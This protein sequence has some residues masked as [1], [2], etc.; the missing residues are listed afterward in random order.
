MLNIICENLKTQLETLPFSDKVAGLTKI[1]VKHVESTLDDGSVY[2]ISESRFPVAYNVSGV[3]CQNTSQ[4]K[5]ISPDSSKKSVMYFEQIASETIETDTTKALTHRTQLRLVVWLNLK[6]LGLDINEE[7]CQLNAIKNQ[8][9]DLVSGANKFTCQNEIRANVSPFRIV[10][11]PTIFTKYSYDKTL[12][13]NMLL[14]PYAYF[15]IDFNVSWVRG[16]NCYA[17]TLQTPIVC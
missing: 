10:E 17:F 1:A 3:R 13:E 9:T 2:K 7:L 15:A 5:D 12:I 11:D 8:V 16:Y 4:Y 14:Y 6:A